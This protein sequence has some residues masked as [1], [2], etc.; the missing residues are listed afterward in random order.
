MPITKPNLQLSPEYIQLA[1]GLE[2]PEVELDHVTPE[3]AR[4]QSEA[5]REA[6]IVLKGTGQQPTWYERFELLTTNGWPW[7]AGDIH[8]LGFN[9]ERRAHAANPDEARK[10]VFEFDKRSSRRHLA[11]QEP[12]DRHNHCNVADCGALGNESGC[13]QEFD[14]RH[15]ASRQ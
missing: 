14:F 11:K 13:I 5:G 9:A 2:L 7:K 3:D 4:I 12:C 1:L 8:C 6:L 15:E 10:R